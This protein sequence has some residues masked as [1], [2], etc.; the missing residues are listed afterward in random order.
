MGNEVSTVGGAVFTAS[1]HV[2]NAVTFGAFGDEAQEIIKE[3]EDFTKKQWEKTAVKSAV[4][5]VVKGTAT[6][7]AAAATAAGRA[8]AA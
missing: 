5:T 3:S 2:T 6:V 7:G 4:D 8:R 1:A